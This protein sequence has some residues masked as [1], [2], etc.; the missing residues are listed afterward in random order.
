MIKFMA[1]S[2]PFYAGVELHLADV[3]E[4]RIAVA[5]PLT[6]KVVPE[7]SMLGDP[8]VRLSPPEAQLLI[9]ALW[10]CGLRPTN[11]HGSTGQ[12]QATERHL[13]DLRALVFK[14]PPK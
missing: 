13:E 6:M 3:S 5:D 11:G 14:R 8:L 7:G 12:L 10:D 4:G 1:R 9:D 2:T